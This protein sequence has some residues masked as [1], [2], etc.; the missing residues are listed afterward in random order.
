LA[1]LKVK[2]TTGKNIYNVILDSV[3]FL[4][5][6]PKY[7]VGQGYDV[8][9]EMSGNFKGLQAIFRKKNPVTLY[10]HRSDHFLNLTLS[11]S[12]SIQIFV[13]VLVP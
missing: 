13:I 12:C 6:N 3:T 4:G 1:W 2:N 9:A 5:I 8:T 7:M 11:H 10:K